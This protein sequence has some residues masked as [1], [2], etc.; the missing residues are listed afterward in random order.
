[1]KKYE[2]VKIEVIDIDHKDIIVSSPEE[3][4]I[5]EGQNFNK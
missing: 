2:E 3:G 1:M 5:P 4:E